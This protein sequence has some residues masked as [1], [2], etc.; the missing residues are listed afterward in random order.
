[1]NLF[2]TLKKDE[3]EEIQEDKKLLDTENDKTENKSEDSENRYEKYSR[4]RNDI[5]KH[6][7]AYYDEDSPLIS[8]KEYDELIRELKSLE[9]RWPELKELYSQE[10]KSENTVTPTEKTE[11]PGRKMA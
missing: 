3:D 1:M 7:K 5:E 4:L 6:N 9:E 8:D 11:K 2:D 10:N